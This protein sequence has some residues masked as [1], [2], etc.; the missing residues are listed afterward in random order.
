MG[1][2]W[3]ALSIAVAAGVAKGL[4]VEGKKVAGVV[5]LAFAIAAPTWWYSTNESDAETNAR[6]D[7][8]VAAQMAAAPDRAL[9]ACQAALKSASRDPAKAVVPDVGAIRDGADHRF[10]WNEKSHQV[11]VH[12]GL[13]VEV[14][15]PALCVVDERTEQ[16][17]LLVLDGTQLVTPGRT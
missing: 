14:A 11:R 17:K 7:R 6:L 5:V 10:L 15:A 13:G 12:N 16:I 1:L 9:R 3:I 8:E 2:L 4:G